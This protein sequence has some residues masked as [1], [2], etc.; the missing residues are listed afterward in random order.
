MIWL[1]VSALLLF[2]LF[3]PFSFHLE[4]RYLAQINLAL[5][6]RPC[7]FS[8]K[9]FCL[10][11]YPKK[12][13]KENKK[14]QTA[15]KERFYIQWQSCLKEILPRFLKH[16]QIKVFSLHASL[17]GNPMT[18]ALSAG[19]FYAG[20]HWL[21]GMLSCHVRRFP[22]PPDVKITAGGSELEAEGQMRFKYSLAGLLYCLIFLV[23]CIHK[24]G[25]ENHHE[26]Q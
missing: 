24:K 17:P 5:Y 2:I 4:G 3:Y 18:A 8:P 19:A 14:Q 1:I 16:L 6:W 26:Q 21:L 10:F 15:K 13:K 23:A 20:L 9:E 12:E 11:R 22:A 25:A 7:P